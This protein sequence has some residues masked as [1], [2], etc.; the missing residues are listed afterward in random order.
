VGK[1]IHSRAAVQ[2]LYFLFII[3]SCFL[4]SQISDIEIYNAITAFIVV[5]ISNTEMGNVKSLEKYHFANSISA[6]SQAL[7]IGFIGP[8]FYITI[9]GNASGIFYCFLCNFAMAGNCKAFSFPVKI[10]NIIPSMIAQFFL[11]FIYIIRNKKW[12]IDFKGDYKYNCVL[13]PTLN[14]DIMAANIQKVNFNFY[15]DDNLT[16]YI[17]SYGESKS[18]INIACIKDYLGIVYASCMVFF[19]LFLIINYF[20]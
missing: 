11:Y 2:A 12:D 14:V 13:N 5:D 18:K 15:Y 10:L 8:L 20:K 3:I 16:S 7:V 17:K 6:L 9:L 19:I 1:V 4:L